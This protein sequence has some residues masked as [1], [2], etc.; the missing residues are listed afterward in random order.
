VLNGWHHVA[1]VLRA[2]KADDMELAVELYLNGQNIAAGKAPVLGSHP[3]DINLGRCG[4]TLFHDGRAVGHPGHYF[5]GRLDDFQII[6]RALTPEE[7]R[8]L[9]NEG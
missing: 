7:I 3:N 8:T 5:A 9:A 2:A 6:N 1:V 4:N